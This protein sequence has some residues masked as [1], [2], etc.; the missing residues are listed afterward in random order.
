MVLLGRRGR[1]GDGGYGA[2]RY[3]ADSSVVQ[4]TRDSDGLASALLKLN[5][6]DGRLD[7]AKA[8]A[9]LFF[10][11]PESDG[12]DEANQPATALESRS[13]LSFHPSIKRRL[14]RPQRV[15][16]HVVSPAAP[17]DFGK[18]VLAFSLLHGRFAMLAAS[19]LLLLIASTWWWWFCG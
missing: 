3:L 16:A 18:I 10:V 7:G 12:S 17:K 13:L 14:E 11:S 15:G 8:A 2:R 5:A 1:A 6:E 9:H 19:I 4:F